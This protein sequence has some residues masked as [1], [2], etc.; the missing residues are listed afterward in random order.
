M[1]KDA[2]MHHTCLWPARKVR[3]GELSCLDTNIEDTW[4]HSQHWVAKI[5][6]IAILLPIVTVLPLELTTL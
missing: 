3:I 1:M 6:V 2:T 4:N 5:A